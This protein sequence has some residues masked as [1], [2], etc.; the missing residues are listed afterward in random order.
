MKFKI[1][2][3]YYK[4]K[5]ESFEIEQ[6]ENM[7]GGIWFVLIDGTGRFINYKEI[8]QMYSERIK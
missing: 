5:V 3:E 4:N 6:F 7:S 1:T 8:K 2:I